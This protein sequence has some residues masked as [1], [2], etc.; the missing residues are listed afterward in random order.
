MRVATFNLE[1]L[2]IPVEPRAPLLGPALERLEADIICF[3]EVNAQ[4]I[5]GSPSRS[6]LAL[7]QLLAGTPYASY[8]RASTTNGEGTGPAD[9]HNLVT[10]SR[11]P[12]VSRRQILHDF[13]PPVAT[14]L[15]TADPEMH[16]PTPVTFDR[17]LLL[18]EHDLGTN[19]IH[20][21]NVHL[22]APIATP[23]PGGKLAPFS[24]R[25]IGTWAEGYYLSGLKRSGQ[26]LELRLLID[27]LFETD[28][29]ALVLVAGDFNAEDHETPLR[30]VAGSAEDT[31]NPGL[32][33]RALVMLDRSLD[34]DRRF[35]VIHHGR[36]QMLDHMLASHGLLGRFRTMEVHN[37]ALGDE[38]VA[39]AKGTAPLGSFHA[40]VVA[41]FAMVPG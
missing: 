9:V 14:R 8:H 1:S 33:V 18:T 40:A 11:F 37:E 13:V 4:S 35:S 23:V 29:L 20:V 28:P 17:P 38:A 6:L 5:R 30:I 10:L 3:Q 25:R 26:A 16:E 34:S 24:W 2:D 15:V 41:D 21:I 7:D 32:A 27:E 36:P 12:I 39:Y 22:R 31:G 19:R